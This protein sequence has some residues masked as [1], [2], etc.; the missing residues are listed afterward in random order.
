MDISPLDNTLDNT[1]T[2]TAKTLPRWRLVCYDETIVD[3]KLRYF[4]QDLS[5]PHLCRDCHWKREDS[6]ENLRKSG[7]LQTLSS[8]LEPILPKRDKQFSGVYEDQRHSIDSVLYKDIK[9]LSY[10]LW[11]NQFLSSAGLAHLCELFM[12]NGNLLK[13]HFTISNFS[14]RLKVSVEVT[15]AAGVVTSRAVMIYKAPEWTESANPRA[16]IWSRDQSAA[17]D[18]LNWSG[19]SC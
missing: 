6:I 1:E 9:C 8:E 7:K 11:L 4:L 10:I 5:P 3:R 2:I 19:A 13:L 15:D 12:R 18:Q 17:R 14:R 16:G